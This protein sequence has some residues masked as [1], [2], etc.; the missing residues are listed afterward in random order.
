MKLYLA[1][2]VRIFPKSSGL[3]GRLSAKINFC[4]WCGKEL[5]FLE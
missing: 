4:P 2:L 3:T 1:C 5:Q